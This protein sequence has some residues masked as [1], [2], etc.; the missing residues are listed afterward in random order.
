MFELGSFRSGRCMFAG[1]GG[2]RA[3]GRWRGG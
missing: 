1:K 2:I 3:Q